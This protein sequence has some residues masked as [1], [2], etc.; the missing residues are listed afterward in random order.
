[1][2]TQ[3]LKNIILD[4]GSNDEINDAS[5][6]DT[7]TEIEKDQIEH[8]K[9]SVF[10]CRNERFKTSAGCSEHMCKV[11]GCPNVCCNNGFIGNNYC[12]IHKC[13]YVQVKQPTTPNVI[14]NLDKTYDSD[15]VQKQMCNNR[16]IEGELYCP[17]HMAELS[18]GL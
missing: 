9:C 15:Y 16:R 8:V 12:E 13:F 4:T 18:Q 3:N 14:T 2:A 6:Y 7:K 17:L 11:S 1:M 10:F 5:G